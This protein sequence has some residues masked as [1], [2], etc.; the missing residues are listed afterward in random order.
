M[1]RTAGNGAALGR[2]R[3]TDEIIASFDESRAY[4]AAYR[5]QARN[6]RHGA[7]ITVEWRKRSETCASILGKHGQR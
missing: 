7:S 4:R 1:P 5:A 3:R 6:L 2:P